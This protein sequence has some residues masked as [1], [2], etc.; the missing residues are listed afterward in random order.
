MFRVKIYVLSV[1]NNLCCQIKLFK[2]L[3]VRCDLFK[4][5]MTRPLGSKFRLW[6]ISAHQKLKMLSFFHF[7]M[8]LTNSISFFQM[9]GMPFKKL[10]FFCSFFSK[11]CPL[12]ELAYYIFLSPVTFHQIQQLKS[13]KNI[14]PRFS[15]LSL[16]FQSLH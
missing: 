2:I 16:D 6:K 11:S 4:I 9:K 14:I 15:N 12:L 1:N 5:L 8:Q 7:F 10:Y 13:R 3:K